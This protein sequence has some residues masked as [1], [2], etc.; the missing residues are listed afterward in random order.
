MCRWLSWFLYDEKYL[1]HQKNWDKESASSV[2][3]LSFPSYFSC[4][5]TEIGFI[6]KKI[7]L[8]LPPT[9]GSRS[10]EMKQQKEMSSNRSHT[11]E[12]IS[13]S[14]RM[15]ITN[16]GTRSSRNRGQKQPLYTDRFRNSKSWY[17]YSLLL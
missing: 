12:L 17:N 4:E 13:K 5:D 11:L 15:C 7:K 16:V 3:L 9:D 6:H 1:Q 2:I 10:L 14:L 8:R